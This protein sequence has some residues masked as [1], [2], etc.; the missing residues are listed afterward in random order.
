MQE[1]REEPALPGG[2]QR[3]SGGA[4]ITLRGSGRRRIRIDEPMAEIVQRRPA[5]EPSACEGGALAPAAIERGGARC[6]LLEPALAGTGA[7]ERSLE[8]T[9]DPVHRGTLRRRSGRRDRGRASA[10]AAG[11]DGDHAPPRLRPPL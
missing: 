11:P 4:L 10:S 3:E 7:F 8:R 1:P 9:A 2:V 6:R 5:S